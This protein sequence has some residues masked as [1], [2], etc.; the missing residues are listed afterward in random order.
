MH[1]FI[2]L[3]SVICIAATGPVYSGDDTTAVSV[4]GYL[5]SDVWTDFSGNFFSNDELD[6]SMTVQFSEKVSAS[7]AATVASGTIPAG[8]GRPGGRAVTVYELT[9]DTFELADE[10]S[11]WVA[12][13]FDGISLL[14]ES[15]AGTFTVGD[16]VYQFGGFNYYLYKR[17]SMIAVESFTRGVGYSFGT[18]ILSQ[19]IMAGS[20]DID[21]TG[22]FAG[23]TSL[24]FDGSHG[25]SLYYGIRGSIHE[26]FTTASTVFA[27]LEYTGSIAG[28]L[29]LKLDFGLQNLP[30]DERLTAYS[31]LFEP[32][33][34]AGRF[35][36]AMSLYAFIDPD[37][38]GAN[39]V[40]DEFF[41]YIEPGYSFTGVIAA[42]LPLEIHTTDM[43][44]FADAGQ[45]WAVPTLYVY[46]AAG[47]EWW[48][49]GQ[50]AVPLGDDETGDPAYGLGSEI[51]MNF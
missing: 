10:Y 5:D 39:F 34:S 51:I 38:S 17:L 30:G 19:S 50:V 46:P 27:G 13:A 9:N 16:L 47:V 45:F 21:R 4:S 40:D 3:C 24:S 36:T 28:M 31:L 33:V 15:P 2:I 37:S 49:W 35:S 18:D 29:D 26:S 48:I 41:A 6:M 25:A 32:A 11:R 23:A 14:Y 44:A 20:A 43:D 7:I 12:V 1:R 22:D 42:G 8:T